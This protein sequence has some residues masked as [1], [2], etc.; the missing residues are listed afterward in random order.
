MLLLSERTCLAGNYNETI[1]R[2]AISVLPSI[3]TM[4]AS[5]A[6]VQNSLN[7]STG[8]G[9]VAQTAYSWAKMLAVAPT[10]TLTAAVWGLNAALLANPIM[11][12]VVAIAALVAALVAAYTFCKPFKDAVDGLGKPI[13]DALKPAIDVVVGALTWFWNNVLVPLGEFLLNVF[14]KNIEAVAGAIRWLAD[15]IGALANWFGDAWVAIT[16]TVNDRVEK[17]MADQLKI[18]EDNLK[19][20]TEEVNKRYDEQVKTVESTYNQ[21]TDAAIKSWEERL[22]VE[23]KGWDKVLKLE[24]DNANKLVDAVRDALSDKTDAIEEANQAQLDSLKSGYDEQID[25]TNSFY[26]EMI[27]TTESKLKGVQ[28]AR[29]DDLN[30]LELTYLLQKQAIEDGV[31]AGTIASAAGQAQIE[32]LDKA[33]NN[34]RRGISEDYRVQELQAE[35]ANKANVE[36]AET[37][38]AAALEKLE[39]DHTV[40]E[41]A[42]LGERKAK[43]AAVEREATLEIQKINEERNKILTEITT[44]RDTIE[45]KHTQDLKEIYQNRENEL[46]EI[47]RKAAD[48]RLKITGNA[49]QQILPPGSSPQTQSPIPQAPQFR[50]GF[51]GMLIPIPPLA[52]GGIVTQP[53][54]ALIGESGP[55]AIVP[56]GNMNT[57]AQQTQ[58]NVIYVNVSIGNVTA[59]VPMEEVVQATSEGVAKGLA[60]KGVL[61]S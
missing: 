43:L 35:L 37:L 2:G 19:K 10:A 31:A 11:L 36:N 14:I 6:T 32:T 47:T 27:S 28:S 42:L 18:V 58:N 49:T 5:L 59:E 53:T 45:N 39:A 48:E 41:V 16:G 3:I 50:M 9:A 56:L 26:D 57:G 29:E 61:L 22:N 17:K 12:V 13:M 46:T 60:G 40:K 38:R 24:N 21:E 23:A 55:E 1:V 7:L 20:Q 51:G 8:A 54:L 52:E 4:T 44:D 34:R 33:Y 30:A 25:A 15:G